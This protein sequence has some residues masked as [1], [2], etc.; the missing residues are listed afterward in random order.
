MVLR[1]NLHLLERI[2]QVGVAQL[3]E[4][5]GG[6]IVGRDRHDG[7][8]FVLEISM[9][10]GD[11]LFIGLGRGAVIAR[12]D[13]D[14]HFRLGEVLKRVGLAVNAG[15]AKVGGLGTDGQRRQA[16]EDRHKQSR[17]VG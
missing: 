17:P 16:R 8:T 1:S 11:P 6:G 12:E 13:H 4:P 9:Q 7:H 15:E 5:H 3:I 2:A 10:V 14:Q